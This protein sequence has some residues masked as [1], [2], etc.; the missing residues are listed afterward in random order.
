MAQGSSQNAVVQVAAAD[1]Q[2]A[3]IVAARTGYAIRVMGYVLVAYAGGSAWPDGA[4]AQVQ[5]R[6]GGGNNLSGLF[7]LRESLPLAVPVAVQTGEDLG[8]YFQTAAGQ[9]LT[10]NVSGGDV[11]G[12][13]TY[14]Y[15]A[16]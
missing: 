1:S 3:I 15:V 5:W 12:H 10:L 6:D 8:G 14:T 13:V 7:N 4:V 2:P 11:S 16:Q 9:A